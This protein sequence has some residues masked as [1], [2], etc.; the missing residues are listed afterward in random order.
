VI[1]IQAGLEGAPGA[2]IGGHVFVFPLA[3]AFAQ[4]GLIPRNNS[5]SH[6]VRWAVKL[7]VFLAVSLSILA[8]I[9]VLLLFPRLTSF[10][11]M[12]GISLYSLGI[13]L[14][15]VGLLVSVITLVVRFSACRV[16]PTCGS[17]SAS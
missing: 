5:L 2:W 4:L 14:A 11:E 17:K 6:R 15:A 12:V 9:E 1:G 13:L 3:V 10:E 8:A 7:A 16:E